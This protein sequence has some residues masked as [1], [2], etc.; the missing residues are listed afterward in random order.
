LV[1]QEFNVDPGGDSGSHFVWERW[2]NVTL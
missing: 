2:W 1:F